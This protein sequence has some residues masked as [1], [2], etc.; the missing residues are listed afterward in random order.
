MTAWLQFVV[1][2][3]GREA[4]RAATSPQKLTC[5]LAIFAAILSVITPAQCSPQDCMLT[6]SHS[7]GEC[8]G[9]PMEEETGASTPSSPNHCCDLAQNPVPTTQAAPFHRFDAHVVAVAVLNNLVVLS[10]NFEAFEVH[11]SAASPPT[12]LQSFF[13]TLLI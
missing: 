9:M 1:R 6:K 5:V 10:P 7:S 11:N 8:Q 4:V 3:G 2:A 13:C 12:D